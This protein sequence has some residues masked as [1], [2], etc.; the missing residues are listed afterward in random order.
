[1]N[2]DGEVDSFLCLDSTALERRLAAGEFAYE[3]ALSIRAAQAA[4]AERATGATLSKHG[5]L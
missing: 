4:Q 1:V 5:E 2:T 3:A